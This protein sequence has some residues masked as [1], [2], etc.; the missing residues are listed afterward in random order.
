MIEVSDIGG[1][2]VLEADTIVLSNQDIYKTELEIIESTDGKGFLIKTRGGLIVIEPIR[3][4]II[5][6]SIK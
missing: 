5:K 2:C 6:I 3:L 1:T 4:D